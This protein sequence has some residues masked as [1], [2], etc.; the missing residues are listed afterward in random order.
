MENRIQEWLWENNNKEHRAAW[1]LPPL[2]ANQSP[3]P[4]SEHVPQ[5]RLTPHTAQQSS[6]RMWISHTVVVRIGLPTTQ[7]CPTSASQEAFKTP[8]RSFSTIQI[9]LFFIIWKELQPWGCVLPPNIKPAVDHTHSAHTQTRTHIYIHLE[10]RFRSYFSVLVSCS[11]TL[12]CRF[13][14]LTQ[15]PSHQAQ[16]LQHL[17]CINSAHIGEN[18]KMFL[19]QNV[20]TFKNH[21]R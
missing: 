17:S 1:P 14:W 21:V 5:A 6:E 16:P 7:S 18:L 9:S 8:P 10:T 3:A 4:I 15:Q 19:L 13:S 12:T 20:L 11:R 2:A